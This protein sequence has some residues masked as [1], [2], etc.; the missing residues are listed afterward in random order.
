MKVFFVRWHNVLAEKELIF[1]G[2]R[3]FA[4]RLGKLKIMPSAAVIDH[5]MGLL[6]IQKKG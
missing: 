6:R 2:L 4:P 1:M 5:P 3:G